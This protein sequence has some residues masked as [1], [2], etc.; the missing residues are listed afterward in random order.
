[1]LQGNVPLRHLLNAKPPFMSWWRS[2]FNEVNDC[3][4]SDDKNNFED[5]KIYKKWKN[6]AKKTETHPNLSK[7]LAL[8]LFK[9]HKEVLLHPMKIA[10]NLANAKKNSD[11]TK[12]LLENEESN[13]K[14]DILT[15]R[16]SLEA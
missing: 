16:Y 13:S 5:E 11:L 2:D 9:M 4:L 12:F 8:I 1:M 14:I 7:D 3:A 15:T 10:V 6:L